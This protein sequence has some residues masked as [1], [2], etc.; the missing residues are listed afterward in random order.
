MKNWVDSVIG[1]GK[2]GLTILARNPG[3]ATVAILTLALGI[4]ANASIFTVVNAVMLRGAPY[5]DTD[6]LVVVSQVNPQYPDT[7]YPFDLSYFADLRDQNQVFESIAGY[8]S[9]TRRNLTG[10]GQPEAVSTLFVSS[11]FFDVLGVNMSAGRGFSSEDAQQNFYRHQELFNRYDSVIIS[12]SLWNLR[13]G[14]DP[15]VIGRRVNIDGQDRTIVGV[16]PALKLPD[17]QP[18]VCIPINM[19]VLGR[20]EAYSTVNIIGRLKPG[21]GMQQAQANIGTINDSLIKKSPG[22][23]PNQ[24]LP[25]VKITSLNK[26]LVGDVKPA[27]MIL[28]AAA[29][30]VLLIACA[31]ISNLLLVRSSVRRKEIAVRSA[32]GA[33]RSRLIRQFLTES[34]MLA[35]LGGAVGL[36]LALWGVKL[37][38]MMAPPNLSEAADAHMDLKVLAFTM[39]ASLVTGIVFGLA[40]ALHSATRDVNEGLKEGG[41]DGGDTSRTRTRNALMIAEIAIAVLLLTGAGLTVRSFS[42]LSKI[43]PGFDVSK[44]LTMEIN[45]PS[46]GPNSKMDVWDYYDKIISEVEALSGVESAGFTYSLPLGGTLKGARH[47]PEDKPDRPIDGLY[48]NSVSP[49]LLKTLG[50]K[51]ISGR[52]FDDSDLK[53]P[54]NVMV[55]SQNFARHHWPNQD[56]IGKPF[57]AWPDMKVIGV[58]SDVHDTELSY[59]AIPQFYVL[60]ERSGPLSGLGAEISKSLFPT[61][62]VVRTKTD[63]LSLAAAIREKIWSINPNQPVSHVRSAE[64][65]L[66]ESKSRQRFN[67]VLMGMFALLAIILAT[68]GI[69]GVISYSVARRTREIGIRMALGAERRDV[70]KLVLWQGFLPL[71]AGLI[72]GTS[73]ALVLTRLMASLLFRVSAKDPATFFVIIPVLAGVALLANCIPALRATKVDPSVALR[74]E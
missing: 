66:W 43:D 35:G 24:G 67:M 41:R 61:V 9:G 48:F 49:D 60:N 74:Y 2:Y 14:S 19:D 12:S 52:L 6:R 56:P 65:L 39:G 32:L 26:E 5:K 3:L 7:E 36:F 4:G 69:Y 30:L 16:M 54:N 44:L 38:A 8:R 63:P 13:F 10:A 22:Y 57:P 59:R 29:C 27:L 37:L 71:A 58:V 51:L 34:M 42:E 46:P 50:V 45:N 1:D 70:I 17:Y 20:E 68:V 72:L 23:L 28:L 11:N 73:T 53:T 21:T 15:G 40:P 64:Q 33:G 62:F 18:D 25:L 47:T 55:V 31:N